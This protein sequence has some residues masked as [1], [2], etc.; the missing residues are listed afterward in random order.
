ML[1]TRT[2][3]R[4]AR[5]GYA[6]VYL[7]VAMVVFCGIVSLAVDL[8]RVQVVKTE[9]R[10]AADAAARAGVAYIS[11]DTTTIRNQTI[12]WAALNKADSSTITLQNSDVEIG[13]W[14][15]NTFTVS[16]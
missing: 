4:R 11:S 12:A 8:A 2:Q 16:S 9:L 1:Y 14:A 5:P 13:K 15:N 7:A 10:Q 3:C 6:I